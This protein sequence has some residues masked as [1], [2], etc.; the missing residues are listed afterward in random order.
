MGTIFYFVVKQIIISGLTPFARLNASFMRN[1]NNPVKV[2]CQKHVYNFI[3]DS[4]ILSENFWLDG[5][6]LNNSGEG[7]LPNNN[8][9]ML[10]DSYFLV[11]SFT[12]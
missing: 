12:Q 1:L 8:F 2:L 11:P 10:N 9:V 6:H 4:K 3:D 7:I 5:L